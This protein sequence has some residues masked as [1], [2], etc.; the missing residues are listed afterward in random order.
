MARRVPQLL[1]ILL[2]LATGAGAQPTLT[3]ETHPLRTYDG[4][5]R[6]VELGR[7]EVPESR[8]APTS[9]T[10]SVAMLR[11]RTTNP[12]PAS[13]I[14]FLMGGPGIPASVMAPIPP[15]WT[16]FDSL[17]SVADVILL[18]QRGLGLSTPNLD[19]PA[20]ASPPANFMTSRAAF[21]AE[22][23]RVITRCTSYFLSRGSSA[24]TLTDAAIA[25]DLE[26]LRKAL[27]V[28]RI[29]LL[30]FSYGTRLALTYAR[31]HPDGV[32]RLVLQ[33]PTDHNL[34][35]RASGW[36]DSLFKMIAREAARDPVS[37]PFAQDLIARTRALFERVSQVPIAVRLGTT[38][39]DSITIHVG[40]QLLAGTIT[41]RIA[42]PR[43]PA[44]I[45]TLEVDDVSILRHWVTTTYQDL[46]NGGGSL[47]ARAI[48]CSQPPSLNR[49]IAVDVT[50]GQTFFGPSLDNFVF[51]LDF[52]LA[53]WGG[54]FRPEVIASKNVNRPTLFIVGSR[55]DRTPP[56]NARLLAADFRSATTL[57][58]EDGGHELLPVL[59]VQREVVRYFRTGDLGRT[60]LRVPTP[61]YLSIEDARVPPRR[62][63]R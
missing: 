61:R 48:T 17:R 3:W 55:D 22:Y 45:A 6:E 4:T 56:Y 29:S 20:G 8:S 47:M 15:Y 46:T 11:L 2:T 30:G 35:Y 36:H 14:I 32:D 38:S 49:T 26:D 7:L 25:D 31:R 34:M 62:P 37:A 50:D 12:R 41:G 57:I 58:V 10:I 44:L 16:L 53:V 27:R 39:G 18:D 43:I 40:A 60:S 24:R 59:E 1:L 33:G 21:V 54:P 28:P 51:D 19:C 52:C 63:G 42:D 23:K 13:P 9:P 5:E